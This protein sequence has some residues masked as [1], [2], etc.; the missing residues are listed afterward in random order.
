MAESRGQLPTG[1]DLCIRLL[2]AAAPR[3]V[4]GA[5]PEVPEGVV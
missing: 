3:V 5:V 2:A 1:L 4:A